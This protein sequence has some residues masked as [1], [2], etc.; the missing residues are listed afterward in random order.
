MAVVRPL[1]LTGSNDLIEMTNSQIDTVKNRCRYLYAQNPSV[2][3]SYASSGGNISPNMRDNRKTAGA[4]KT[5][6]T[7]YPAETSTDEPGNAHEDFDHINQNVGSTSVTADTNNVAFPI[8]YTGSNIQSMSLTDF[9]DTFIYPAIDT[10]TSASN[11][12]GMF[13]IHNNTSLP[14]YSRIGSTS[15]YVFR[16]TRADTSLYTAGGI[17]ET[18]RLC[19]KVYCGPVLMTSSLV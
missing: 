5:S 2:T 6:V 10:L 1:I 17:P 13:R 16:D 15:Q 7:T 14:G 4:Y 11:Q 9:R 3:L 19:E 8:Y 18:M 12:P